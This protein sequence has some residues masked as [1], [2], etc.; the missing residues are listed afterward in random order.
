MLKNRSFYYLRHGQTEWNLSGRAQGQQDLELNATGRS[1]AASA[2]AKLLRTG[3]TAICVSPL[4]R[5]LE[6]ASIIGAALQVPTLVVDDLKEACWGECEGSLKGAWF[7][8]WKAGVTPAGAEPFVEFLG[9]G[10]RGLNTALG[11][12]ERVLIVA[13]GGTYWAVGS[14]I[15][16]RLEE[17]VP[18][19]TP[20]YHSAP[21]QKGS[22]W[23]LNAL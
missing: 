14:A 4:K 15:G 20:I 3:I 19:C 6:T 11:S 1:Q 23:T 10:L 13:H 17:D 9:R 18:N 2:I 16:V 5:A 21:S 7:E 8:K 12:G 22:P